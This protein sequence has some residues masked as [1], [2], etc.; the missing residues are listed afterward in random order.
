MKPQFFSNS[1]EFRTWLEENHDTEKELLVGFYKV[2]TG[3]PSMTWS[4]SVDEALCFGWID[5]IR[6]SIDDES[7][8]IRFT[9][10]NLSSNWSKINIDKVNKLRRLGLMRPAGLKVFS[11]RK[12]ER[13]ATYSFENLPKKFP[14]DYEKKF[15]ENKAA[16][17]FFRKQAPSY[18][19]TITHWILAAKQEK[20]KWS[21]LEKLISSSEKQSRLF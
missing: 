12:E 21:R 20:T 8:C 4:E 2:K 10:R 6:K 9:P 15:K 7:Y 11:Q 3:K 16:W 13:S 5:G 18:Q 14:K 19:K 1:S 17:D